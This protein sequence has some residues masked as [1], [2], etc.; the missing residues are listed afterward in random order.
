MDQT[1]Q[2]VINMNPQLQAYSEQDHGYFQFCK[3]YD[4]AA[5]DPASMTEFRNWFLA[6]LR[7]EGMRIAAIEEGVEQGK[8]LGLEQGRVLGIKQGR[9]E[10]AV[11][12]R[13]KWRHINEAKD[14]EIARLRGL[15]AEKA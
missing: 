10:G 15:L 13:E 8:T 7:E 2:E 11:E 12:E 14:N 9:E 6:E 4:R 1:I 3:Q 5:A